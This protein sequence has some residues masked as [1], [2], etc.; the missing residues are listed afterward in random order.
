[1]SLPRSPRGSG[2][3]VIDLLDGVV[4]V[5]VVGFRFLCGCRGACF[6]VVDCAWAVVSRVRLIWKEEI[7]EGVLVAVDV[8]V[9]GASVE[10]SVECATIL[11][12]V[13]VGRILIVVS[14]VVVDADAVKRECVVPIAVVE[15]V[16]MLLFC[17]LSV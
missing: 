12:A 1:M 8:E 7:V 13:A 5:E 11:G 6:I 2:G 10:A 9:V 14:V 15:V 4:V 17:L 16:A 3:Y